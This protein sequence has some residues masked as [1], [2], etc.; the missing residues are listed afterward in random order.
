MLVINADSEE[1]K[2]HG[3]KQPVKMA[4][5]NWPISVPVLEPPF[6]LGM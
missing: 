6:D 1:L 3:E 5:C 2:K 4:L